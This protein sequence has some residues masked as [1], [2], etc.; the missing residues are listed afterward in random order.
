[1]S[2]V[3][4]RKGIDRI[5]Q[6]FLSALDRLRSGKP[7]NAKLAKM[8]TLDTLRITVSTVALEAGHS[9][10]LIGHKNC[11]YPGTRD[12]I[13]AL[14]E[15]RDEPRTAADIITRK[16]EEV[17]A[18]RRKLAISHSEM[19]A[20]VRRLDQLQAET[21]RKAR[22]V[23]RR[24]SSNDL[25]GKVFAGKSTGKVIG[26]PRIRSKRNNDRD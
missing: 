11:K 21:K 16:R 15:D 4:E 19:A 22:R 13:L 25:A 5:E 20:L 23:A 24:A 9:R 12:R 18:L 17:A 26:F 3:R 10:T 8:A 6:D 7:T 2:M 1:M 14:R